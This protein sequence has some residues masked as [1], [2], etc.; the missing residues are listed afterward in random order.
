MPQ[1]ADIAIIGA[2]A[3]G[4]AAGISRFALF[5]SIA[6]KPLEPKFWFLG[7]GAAM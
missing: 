3:A 7:V 6:P 1:H 5:S 2:G 4:L